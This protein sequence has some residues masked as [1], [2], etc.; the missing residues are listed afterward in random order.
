MFAETPFLFSFTH[1]LNVDYNRDGEDKKLEEVM[2]RN[3]TLL[4]F[5]SHS[6]ASLLRL[7]VP[8]TQPFKR[9]FLFVF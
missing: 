6:Q 2:E 4:C 7:H 8:Y 3:P 1:E 9:F 5:Y